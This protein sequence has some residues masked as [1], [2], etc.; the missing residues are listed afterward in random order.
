MIQLDNISAATLAD[1]LNWAMKP[2]SGCNFSQKLKE[3]SES[4]EEGRVSLI[5][6]ENMVKMAL[7]ELNNEVSK[8]DN[9]HQEPMDG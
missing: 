4:K 1:I 7:R 6:W 2:E 5:H 3:M 9:K 8:K